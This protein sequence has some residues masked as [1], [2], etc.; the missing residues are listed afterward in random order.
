MKI[1][2]ARYDSA[3]KKLRALQTFQKIVDDW[4]NAVKDCPFKEHILAI[5]I[6][7]GVVTLECENPTDGTTN[8]QATQSK[9]SVLV[10]NG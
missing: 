8:G 1:T 3:K 5:S 2:K 7:E 6:K 10:G 4:N 9:K